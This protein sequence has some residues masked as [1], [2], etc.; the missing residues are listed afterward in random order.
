MPIVQVRN[1]SMQE[2]NSADALDVE[3]KNLSADWYD[4]VGGTGFI[5][6]TVVPMGTQRHNDAPTLFS[7]ASNILTILEAGLYF[8][9]FA[10]TA[11]NSGSAELITAMTLDEDPDTTVFAA[12]PGTLTYNTWFNGSGTMVNTALLQ[13]GANYRYKL[14]VSRIGGAVTPTLVQNA[15]HL[16]VVRLIKHG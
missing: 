1:T 3:D 14:M 12:V 8:F 13:V 6:S 2:L 4:S 7:M 5:A 16:S 15:S 10:A 11:Q 9:N